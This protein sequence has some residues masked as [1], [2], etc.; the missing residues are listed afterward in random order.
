MEMIR[1]RNVQNL[2]TTNKRCT[3]ASGGRKELSFEQDT[4]DPVQA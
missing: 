4:E 2:H 1:E 3:D